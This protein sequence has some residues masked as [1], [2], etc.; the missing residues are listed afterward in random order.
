MYVMEHPCVYRHTYTL[1][2]VKYVCVCAHLPSRDMQP[3]LQNVHIGY[4]WEVELQKAL[5]FFRV[6]SDT[7]E[8]SAETCHCF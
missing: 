1:V 5:I 8:F 2:V 4:L 3:V 7:F 6:L